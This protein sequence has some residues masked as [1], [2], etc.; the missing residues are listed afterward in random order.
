MIGIIIRADKEVE[1]LEKDWVPSAFS[2]S[3][4]SEAF[5]KVLGYVPSTESFCHEE[6]EALIY[7]TIDDLAE[8]RAV[9]FNCALVGEQAEIIKSIAGILGARVYDSE[10]GAI[11]EVE[12]V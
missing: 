6:G 11:V 12:N 5:E 1:E 7:F 10:A 8:P 3:E 2:V 4:L 9:T